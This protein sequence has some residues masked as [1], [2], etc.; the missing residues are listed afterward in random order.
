MRP[1]F[2]LLMSA[3]AGGCATRAVPT[4]FPIGSAASPAS[5]EAPRRSVTVTLQSDPPL[6]GEPVAEWTGLE[7]EPSAQASQ[8]QDHRP[9]T[10]PAKPPAAAESPKHG[11][12]R[13]V[14]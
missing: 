12:D 9:A 4:A 7:P 5:P 11:G 10:A 3:L 1:A 14:H 8:P 6:P 2:L 13:H